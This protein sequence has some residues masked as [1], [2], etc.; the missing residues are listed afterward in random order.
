[1]VEAWTFFKFVILAQVFF[2]V[3]YTLIINTVPTGYASSQLEMYGD[4]AERQTLEDASRIVESNIG[5]QA[6]VSSTNSVSLIAFSLKLVLDLMF[7]FFFAVPIMIGLLSDSFLFFI[8][9]DTTIA[10]YFKIFFMSASGLLYILM[11]T[12]FILNVRSTST[13]VI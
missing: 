3:S 7:N 6:E 10:F 9:V 12:L 11:L 8:N 4:L 5:Q 2:S 13:S 1:M